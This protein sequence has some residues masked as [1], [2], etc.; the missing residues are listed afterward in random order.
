MT[1]QEM[2]K[3]A[4]DL[5]DAFNTSDWERTGKLLPSDSVYSEL[6]TE[7]Q[8]RGSGQI[9]EAMKGWKQ[10]MPDVKG[11]V[12]NALASGKKVSLEVTW[13]GTQTGPFVGPSGTIPPTGKRQV[14]PAAWIFDFDGDKIL[15]SRHYFDMLTFLKQIGAAPK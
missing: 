4:R 8:I 12:T 1:D 2:V 7:R 9:I 11:T 13:Q 15:E 6:G 3:V 14:T 5:V 10:A